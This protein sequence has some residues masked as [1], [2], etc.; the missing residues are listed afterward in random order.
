MKRLKRIIENLLNHQDFHGQMSDLNEDSLM[1]DA[2]N[3]VLL[4]FFKGKCA[5]TNSKIGGLPYPIDNNSSLG[6]SYLF[7]AQINFEEMPNL[8]GFPEKGILQ[9]YV[10]GDVFKQNNEICDNDNLFR[11]IYT[12]NVSNR[13]KESSVINSIFEEQRIMFIPAVSVINWMDFR[14]NE[15]LL[16][17]YQGIVPSAGCLD[18]IPV[19]IRDKMEQLCCMGGSRIGG[20]PIF[21]DDDPRKDSIKAHGYTTLLFQIDSVF[22]FSDTNG[23]NSYIDLDGIGVLNFLINPRNL[24]NEDFQ[25]VPFCSQVK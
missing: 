16:K 9:F 14:Y 6:E 13:E 23:H 11:I 4:N 5:I 15:Y 8:N 20:Y 24:A 18:E 12:K 7:L 21:I 1:V 10:K 25:D 3:S 19:E 2:E 22:D 17:A